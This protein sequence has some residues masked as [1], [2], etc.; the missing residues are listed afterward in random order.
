MNC[1][2]CGHNIRRRRRR[3]D[4]TKSVSGNALATMASALMNPVNQM[5]PPP[6][7]TMKV[8]IVSCFGCGVLFTKEFQPNE[9][10]PICLKTV[11]W[12]AVGELESPVM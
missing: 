1:P 10:C 9:T 12:K 8:K 4:P 3:R 11:G 7:V 2:K 5:L 6:K